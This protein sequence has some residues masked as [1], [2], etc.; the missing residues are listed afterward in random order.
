[1]K[2]KI[3]LFLNNYFFI[4]RYLL[5]I[6]YFL[7][8]CLISVLFFKN[9]INNLLLLFNFVSLNLF[10]LIILYFKL[11]Q[12]NHR[13]Q[14]LKLIHSLN[15]QNKKLVGVEI[16]V[17]NGDH[18]KKIYD[19]FKTKFDFNFY[20]VDPWKTSSSFNEYEEIFLEKCYLNVK[21]KF[22]DY[23]KI[24]I[25]RQTSV[26]A[27]NNFENESLDFVY[28]DGNHNY[29]YV[30]KD[31]EIWF[32]KLKSHGVLFGDDYS[33]NYGVHKAV[34]EFSFKHKLSV[35]FSDNYKQFCF[36]KS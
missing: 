8:L 15:I 32:L 18:S 30:L 6:F 17:L 23:K 26:E 16:G 4:I 9:E 11:P 21:K 28:I 12:L 22:N 2:K 14:F 36:I 1:M 27:S 24:T 3:I 10:L 33:R 25:L 5:I 31:L 35:K 19:F 7:A 34:S 29:D 13:L 20:L